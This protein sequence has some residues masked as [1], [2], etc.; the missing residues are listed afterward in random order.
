MGACFGVTPLHVS[1]TCAGGKSHSMVYARRPMHG[2]CWVSDIEG[3]PIFVFCQG[4]PSSALQTFPG[5]AFALRRIRSHG[6]RFAASSLNAGTSCMGKIVTLPPA[7]SALWTSAASDEHH[8]QLV[9]TPRRPCV[10]VIGHLHTPHVQLRPL[11]CPSPFQIC[12][13]FLVG[14]PLP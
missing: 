1:F 12:V 5:T 13:H 8:Q 4:R 10:S 2:H 7:R 14:G 3:A 6:E 9:C 11:F